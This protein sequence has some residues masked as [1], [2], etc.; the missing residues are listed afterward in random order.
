MKIEIN[1]KVFDIGF[2]ADACVAISDGKVVEHFF[3][4]DMD[5]DDAIQN[6]VSRIQLKYG[7]GEVKE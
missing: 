6:M 3:V 5:D 1:K 7:Y 4:D 2:I